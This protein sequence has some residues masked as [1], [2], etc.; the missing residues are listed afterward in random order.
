MR[1]VVKNRR[2]CA[3]VL[4]A[5]AALGAGCAAVRPYAPLD[6]SR[7]KGS[8]TLYLVPLSESLTGT[9][10]ELASLYRRKYGLR[11]EVKRPL[12]VPAAAYDAGRRQLVA[13]EVVSA[14]GREYGVADAGQ[15]LVIIGVTADDMYIGGKDWSY[16]FSYRRD[17][18][19]V[20]SSARMD[21]GLF[22][23]KPASRERQQSRLRKMI[24]KNVGV[25]YFRLPLSD[26]PRSVLYGNVG[27]PQELDRMGEDF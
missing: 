23:L 7:L 13:E 10:Y 12:R 5:L 16:A 20:V 24:T 8:G 22:G 4:M 3:L 2:L 18:V 19:A 15:E 26:D 21:H 6:V 11:V 25:L 17:G 1:T 27:G 9:L 14:L